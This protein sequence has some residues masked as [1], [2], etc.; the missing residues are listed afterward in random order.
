MPSA[1]SSSGAAS[2]SGSQAGEVKVPSVVGKPLSNFQKDHA[3]IPYRVVTAYSSEYDKDVI[4]DLSPKAGETLKAGEVLTITVSKGPE[5]VEM[6]NI[7]GKSWDSVKGDLDAKKIKYNVIH[8]YTGEGADG[9]VLATDPSAG[10]KVT[11]GSTVVTVR[12]LQKQS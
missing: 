7:V 12:V 1:G 6:P 3:D 8:V 10:T 11:P 5:D 9:T 4:C 2:S